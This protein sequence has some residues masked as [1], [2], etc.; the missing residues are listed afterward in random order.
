MAFIAFD[1]VFHLSPM[2]IPGDMAMPGLLAEAREIQT[3]AQLTGFV[4]GP[5]VQ[6]LHKLIDHFLAL[7]Q[8]L[9]CVACC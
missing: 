2:T 9:A 6:A 8:G 5:R 4:D 1:Y 3:Q 7:I